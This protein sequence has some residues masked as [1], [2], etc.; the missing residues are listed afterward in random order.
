MG[1]RDGLAVE[2]LRWE[3]CGM[4]EDCHSPRPRESTE[5]TVAVVEP[6]ASPYPPREHDATLAERYTPTVT[7]RYY[8]RAC[9]RSMALEAARNT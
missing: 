2:E 5:A 1:G 4:E 6:A 3:H 7:T 9:H 8:L